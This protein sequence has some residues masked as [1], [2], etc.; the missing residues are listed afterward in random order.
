MV[1]PQGQAMKWIKNM[2]MDKVRGHMQHEFL[3]AS[4]YNPRKKTMRHDTVCNN[5]K[6]CYREVT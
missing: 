2:E 4:I 3:S 6:V 1:D 5:R